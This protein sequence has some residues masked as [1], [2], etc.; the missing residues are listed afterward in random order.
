MQQLSEGTSLSLSRTLISSVHV[1]RTLLG[2]GCPNG[3]PPRGLHV[4][5]ATDDP[6]TT[7]RVPQQ[8]LPPS[9]Y[10]GRSTL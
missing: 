8:I 9:Q 3:A 1:R 7:P 6:I 5:G 2:L 10:S 4:E